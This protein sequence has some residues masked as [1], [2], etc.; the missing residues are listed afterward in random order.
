MREYVTEW[1]KV[2]LVNFPKPQSEPDFTWEREFISWR[3]TSFYYLCV[4]EILFERWKQNMDPAWGYT[5]FKFNFV[6]MNYVHNSKELGWMVQQTV[7]VSYDS[8]ERYYDASLM[9]I[10]NNRYV[11]GYLTNVFIIQSRHKNFLL[12]ALFDK[13]LLYFQ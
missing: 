5:Q 11:V 13:K 6:G 1:R 8:S 7:Q 4:F 2:S 12:H 9:K 10:R 3:H